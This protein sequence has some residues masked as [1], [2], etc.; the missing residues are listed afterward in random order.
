LS[1]LVA[2]THARKLN[3]PI[4]KAKALRKPVSHARNRGQINSK[5]TL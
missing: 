1:N 5:P 4:I 3:N 2:E